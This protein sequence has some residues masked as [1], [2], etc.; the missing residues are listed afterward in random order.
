ML[1]KVRLDILMKV[2]DTVVQ[3]LNPNPPM[4]TQA[5]VISQYFTT[6]LIQTEE[7]DFFLLLISIF[8]DN[9]SRV[10]EEHSPQLPVGLVL[11]C[12]LDL[13]VFE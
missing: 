1:R 12:W 11:P 13:P 5:D 6:H 10:G 4:F 7:G 8:T 3:C 9:P 2:Y